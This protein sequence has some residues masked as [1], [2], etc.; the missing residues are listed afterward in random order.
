MEKHMRIAVTGSSGF[1]GSA[2]VSALV[3]RGDEVIRFI[4]PTSRGHYETAIRWDPSINDID[5]ND[6]RRLGGFDAVVNLAGAGIA[7]RRWTASRK[8]EIFNSRINATRLL[9]EVLGNL[10]SGLPF[11]A[12]GSAI[13]FYGSRGDEIL[14]ENSGPGDG[15][16]ANICVK[17]ENEASRLHQSGASVALL[18]TGVVMSASGGALKKQLPLFRMGLGGRLSTGRQWMSQISLRDEIRGIL[19]IIDHKLTGPVNLVA[20]TPVTNAEFTKEL[21]RQLHRPAMVAVPSFAL[22]IALGRELAVEAVLASQ[23]IEPTVLNQSNF[24]FNDPDCASL[25][26]STLSRTFN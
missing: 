12:S 7:D 22:N 20:P 2:L 17:W 16:L 8:A 15:Y 24:V 6:L 4:R 14:D 10:A 9:V 25:L 18:R 19:W 3:A 1:I 13:G 23:R 21:A 11:L 26:R 5:E